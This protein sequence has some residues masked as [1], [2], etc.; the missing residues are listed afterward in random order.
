MRG[1]CFRSEVEGGTPTRKIAT[2]RKKESFK[3]P[4]KTHIIITVYASHVAACRLHRRSVAS[5]NV[6]GTRPLQFFIRSYPLPP[7]P[8]SRVYRILTQT[9]AFRCWFI[10]RLYRALYT[11]FGRFVIN[12]SA[13]RK[14][15][16]DCY[17]HILLFIICIHVYLCVSVL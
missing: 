9:S 15:T 3:P 8:S 14:N 1:W 7:F 4:L 11:L 17:I 5:V 10:V 2:A 16:R 6:T 12:L 13:P